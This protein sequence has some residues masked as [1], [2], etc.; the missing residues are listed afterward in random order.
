[1]ILEG[2]RLGG[3]EALQWGV[4]D[5]APSNE[6]ELR[7]QL[8]YLG[9]KAIQLGK[10]PLKGLPFKVSVSPRLRKA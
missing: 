8:A 3:R 1:M 7:S 6:S 9:V 10:R 4:A 5:V 2:K